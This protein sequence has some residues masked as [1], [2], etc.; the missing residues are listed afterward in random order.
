M[1]F[2]LLLDLKVDRCFLLEPQ[3]LIYSCRSQWG[4]YFYWRGATRQFLQTWRIFTYTIYKYNVHN[5]RWDASNDE[6]KADGPSHSEWWRITYPVFVDGD[7]VSCLGHKREDSAFERQCFTEHN[8]IWQIQ[9]LGYLV[10]WRNIYMMATIV[11]MYRIQFMRS[12]NC[13][14]IY[15]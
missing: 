8:F 3:G 6:W 11:E 10:D 13:I 12:F 5:S 15:V 4:R 9:L 7:S 14:I 1:F 2:I